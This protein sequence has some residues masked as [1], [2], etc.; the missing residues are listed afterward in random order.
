MASCGELWAPAAGKRTE[1]PF[2]CLLGTLSDLIFPS[3]FQL[4]P[5]YYPCT[6]YDGFDLVFMQM[7]T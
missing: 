1:H 3:V 5:G 6:G 4:V 2:Q 7:G